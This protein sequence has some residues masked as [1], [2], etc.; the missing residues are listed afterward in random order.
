[1][2]KY[3]DKTSENINELLF[4][5]AVYINI[6]PNTIEGV[7]CALRMEFYTKS[8][9]GISFTTT[10]F[11]GIKT[12]KNPFG[13][14]QITLKSHYFPNYQERNNDIFSG[15]K[16]G[17]PFLVPPVEGEYFWRGI[18][19]NRDEGYLD[20][21]NSISI[22]LTGEYQE[23]IDS[24]R[25]LFGKAWNLNILNP[26]TKQS[27]ME[28]HLIAVE[29]LD[30]VYFGDFIINSEEILK[31]AECAEPIF[32]ELSSNPIFRLGQTSSD[33]RNSLY[34]KCDGFDKVL[35]IQM[36]TENWFIDKYKPRKATVK[37]GKEEKIYHYSSKGNIIK[38]SMLYPPSEHKQKNFIMFSTIED[39]PNNILKFSDQIYGGF[40]PWV[41]FNTINLEFTDEEWVSFQVIRDLDFKPDVLKRTCVVKDEK[42]WLSLNS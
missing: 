27:L 40:D 3:G 15:N 5:D 6:G 38:K 14:P 37:L 31:F 41:R 42:W 36:P 2:R 11:D 10:I 39:I 1:M 25:Y 19:F 35:G 23:Y 29:T 22:D 8:G 20:I 18:Y 9:E 32:I 13:I 16:K 12:G 30:K 26:K 21:S 7:Q 28:G 4:N 34:L 17:I 33:L 24:F